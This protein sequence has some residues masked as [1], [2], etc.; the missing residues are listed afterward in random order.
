MT[1]TL[2]LIYALMSYISSELDD[3]FFHIGSADRSLGHKAP[4][5]LRIDKGKASLQGL[6]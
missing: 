4:E 2:V 5:S 1:G 6:D 3:L